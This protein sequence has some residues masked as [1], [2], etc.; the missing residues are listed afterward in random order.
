MKSNKCQ[1]CGKPITGDRQQ[2]WTI[3]NGKEL[4]CEYH[5]ECADKITKPRTLQE[6]LKEVT[7]QVLED[8]MA[9]RKEAAEKAALAKIKKNQA[10]LFKHIDVLLEFV[11]KHDRTS[12]NDEDLSNASSGRCSRCMLL[13]AKRDGYAG[14]IDVSVTILTVPE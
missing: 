6:A 4:V 13:A 12:C 9:L 1:E 2:L 11:D 10:L 14:G 8:E 3:V 7:D 5:K